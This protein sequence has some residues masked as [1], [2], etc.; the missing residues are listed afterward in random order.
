[1]RQD[2]TGSRQIQTGDLTLY[3]D[4][5]FFIQGDSKSQN[6]TMP[7]WHSGADYKGTWNQPDSSH[8]NLFLAPKLDGMFLPYLIVKLTSEKLVLISTFYN[9]KNERLYLTYRRI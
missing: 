3:P 7:G 4:S 1:M 2:T 9:K 6:S 8:L 5:T